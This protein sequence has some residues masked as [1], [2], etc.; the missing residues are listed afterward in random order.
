MNKTNITLMPMFLFIVAVGV[1]GCTGLYDNNLGSKVEW[2]KSAQT[3]NRA[4]VEDDA[5][6][7]TLEGQKAEKLMSRYRK[8]EADAPTERLLKD[9]GD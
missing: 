7:A 8:E 4:A 1:T 2:N 6:I 5:P 3:V 9:I